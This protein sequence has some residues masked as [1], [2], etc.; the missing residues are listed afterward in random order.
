MPAPTAYTE[1]QLADFM[2][3]ELGGT[4]SAL[5]WEFGT[6]QLLRAVYAVA[7]MLD[8]AD[9]ATVTDMTALEAL[10]RLSIW[11]AAQAGSSH[12]YR[13]TTDGQTLDLQQV[14]DH[15]VLM[16]KHYTDQCIS[17][18]VPGVGGSGTVYQH[19]VEYD[20]D[21]YGMTAAAGAEF[22]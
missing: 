4:A 22:G 2:L 15:A 11:R 6:P 8:V 7:R 13:I 19:P 9:V 5:G 10:A 17:L 14:F 18:G 1:S 3:D 16:V 12:R 21:P 20:Q